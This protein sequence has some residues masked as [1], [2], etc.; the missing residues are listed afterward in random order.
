MRNESPAFL[1]GPS[2]CPKASHGVL[3]V[4]R[5]FQSSFKAVSKRFQSV[6]K[7]VSHPDFA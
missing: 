4:P 2:A 7:A 6:F 1:S 5:R 3:G